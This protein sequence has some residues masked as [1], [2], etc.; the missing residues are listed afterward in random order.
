MEQI[1]PWQ[2]N[3]GVIPGVRLA[4]PNLDRQKLAN[5]YYHVCLYPVLDFVVG[6]QQ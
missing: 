4:N 5:L 6:A 1:I 3:L 2:Q